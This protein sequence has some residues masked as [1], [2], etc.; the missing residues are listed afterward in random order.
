M[1][2]RV[3]LTFHSVFYAPFYVALRGGFFAREGLTVAPETIGNGEVLLQRMRA[4]ELDAGIGGVM[5]SMVAHDQGDPEPP[6]HIAK[7]NDRDGFFLVGRG[8]APA[9]DW[10]RLL[11]KRLILFSEAPTPWYVLRGFLLDRGLDPDAIDAVAG[12]PADQAL[13]AFRAGEADFLEVQAAAAETLAADGAGTIVKDVGTDVPPIPY[14]SYGVMPALLR[15]RPDAVMA[16]VRGHRAALDWITSVSGAEVW[17]TIRPDFPDGA[18]E[19][20]QRAVERY[21]RLGTWHGGASLDRAGYER[22][23]HL[24]QRGGLL[25]RIAPYELVVEDLGTRG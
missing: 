25:T 24:L 18:S 10:P 21:H 7:I 5:R 2:L 15:A 11:G 1:R 16:L 9:F 23:G 12:L 4:G 17:E 3:G 14:S 22:L 8:P 19:V 13:A 6:V 20:M